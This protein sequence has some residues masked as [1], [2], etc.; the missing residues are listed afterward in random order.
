[1]A[2]KKAHDGRAGYAGFGACAKHDQF[3]VIAEQGGEQFVRKL[4][5]IVDEPVQTL[6]GGEDQAGGVALVIDGDVRLAIVLDEKA[7][8]AK[9]EVEFH[10]VVFSQE[11]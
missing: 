5:D 4:A 6:L 9:V 8:V 7:L 1:M 11:S 10:S 3:G 2:G